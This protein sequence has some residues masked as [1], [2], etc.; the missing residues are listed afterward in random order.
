MT[1]ASVRIGTRGSALARWQT[2]HVSGLLRAQYPDLPTEIQVISTKGDEVLDKALPLIGGKGL[3]TEALESALREGSIDCAV[4]SLK[5][6]P[7]EDAEG[8]R[9]GAIPARAD[10]RDVLVSQE[11]HTLSELPQGATIGTSSRRRAAQLLH[12]RPDLKIVDI[13]GN[14]GTRIRKVQDATTDYDATLLAKA[15]LDRLGL[16]EHIS[17][18]LSLN[19]MLTAPGQGA[20]GVQCRADDAS[21]ARFDPLNHTA[22]R[23]AA[24]TER[25]FL[26]TL[27]GGCSVPVAAY[28]TVED[29]R[30]HLRGRVISVDGKQMIE[31]TGDAL[32]ADARA[33]A[34]DLA[35][36][37]RAQ[38]ADAILEA[39]K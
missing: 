21:Q 38:G 31:V 4:H 25:E 30:V 23:I 1:T 36:E 6:L 3:F 5:D 37:A 24:E 2:N 35:Q 11:G 27:E 39:I 28:A 33:M 34:V 18:V 22:T 29:G 26:N 10:V 16:A 17:E 19:I 13:R 14:V 9:V 32:I 8:L 7:T 15:G 20:L 12:H